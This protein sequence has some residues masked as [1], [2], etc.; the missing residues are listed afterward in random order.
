MI[1]VRLYGGLGNQ[2]FQYATGRRLA[3]VN[4]TELGLDISDLLKINN[5]ITKRNFELWRYP[6]NAR[7]LNSKEIT[8]TNRYKNR[9]LRRLPLS[10]PWTSYEE[11]FFNF[12][13][14]VLSLNNEVY[15][16]GYWQSPKYFQDIE[17]ILIKELTSTHLMGIKDE[18]ISTEIKKFNSVS[19][20]VRRG[21]Y[22]S[23]Q[24]VAKT[25]GVCTLDYYHESI[26]LIMSRIDSPKFFIFSDDVEWTRKN[27]KINAPTEYVSHN[28]EETAFQDLRLMSLCQNQIIANSSFSWWGA[29]LNTN[30]NKLVVSPKK[31]FLDLRDT[32]D[33]TPQD[34]LRI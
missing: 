15:L 11:K 4:N 3:Y 26:E 12:D 1:V 29:W 2:L 21:D 27:L 24:S 32:G 19:L 13:P 16:D 33:I 9:I 22:V 28:G 17:D 14:N 5:K 25:H 20:H 6:I 23:V 30:K 18:A 7:L 10:R 31:W 34:W 8:I